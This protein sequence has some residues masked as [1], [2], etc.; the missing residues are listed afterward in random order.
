MVVCLICPHSMSN[1]PIV[2]DSSAL[3]EVETRSSA[4]SFAMTADGQV[5]VPLQNG[6]RVRMRRNPW[7]LRLLKI[8]GRS[9]FQTLRAKLR[10]EGAIKHA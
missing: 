5:L 10:W 8:S 6:D 7:P 3:I 4:V 9:F 2:V 1:R